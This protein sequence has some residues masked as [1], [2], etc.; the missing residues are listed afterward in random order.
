MPDNAQPPSRAQIIH[1]II[2]SEAFPWWILLKAAGM[3]FAP[4]VLILATLATAGTWAGFSLLDSLGLPSGISTNA[5]IADLDQTTISLP[6]PSHGVLPTLSSQVDRLPTPVRDLLL[7]LSKPWNPLATS[8]QFVGSLFR[9]IWFLLVWSIFATA[10]TRYVAL[11]LV[12]EEQPSFRDALRFG[13]QKWPATFNSAAFVFFGIVALAIPGALLGLVM[14]FD[15][16]L[17]VVGVLW[18]LILLG[19]VV[20][21][22]LGI[23]LAAGWPLMVAAVGVER[24]DSFQA[25]STAFSYLYQRPIHFAFYGFISCVLAVL[26]FFA[27]GLFADTTVL[28]ALWAGSF[29][30]GHDRTADVIGA[31]AKRGADP[32]WGIQALQFWT[33]SLRVLLGSFGWGFFWSIAPAIYLLL[34]QSVD[35]TEL[36]E[37]VLDEPV[38]A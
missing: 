38:G 23:G 28:F 5:P 30:M 10:I 35:A 11:R 16:G 13:T 18:P 32:R 14:R 21:A 3:A 8:R 4:T 29:G 31:M 7:L 36:D 6:T 1:E 27:A 19:A 33:N 26:G 20:L 9:C 17:A 2:W 25:I 15:W 12:D 34:R 24:G 37:I 22:I